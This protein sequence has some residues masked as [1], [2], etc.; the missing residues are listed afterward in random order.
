M[1]Y[2]QQN[3]RYIPCYPTQQVKH[4]SIQ[5]AKQIEYRIIVIQPSKDNKKDSDT[6]IYLIIFILFGLFLYHSYHSENKKQVTETMIPKS[7]QMKDVKLKVNW[8]PELTN[9][10]FAG[11]GSV[12]TP[13]KG[14]PQHTVNLACQYGRTYNVDPAIFLGIACHERGCMRGGNWY[15]DFVF[16]Y[17]FTDDGRMPKYAGWMNQWKWAAPRIGNYFKNKAVNAMTFMDFAN[18]IYKTTDWAH[19]RSAYNHYLKYK[20]QLNCQ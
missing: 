7:R 4:Y 9:P 1:E 5:Q 18:R 14:V 2:L 15:D 11:Q 16:G 13:I 6:L 20:H 17:G 3:G 10:T 19:Y 8:R 12:G